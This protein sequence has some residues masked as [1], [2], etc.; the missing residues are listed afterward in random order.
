MKTSLTIS[1]V[2]LSN[3]AHVFCFGSQRSPLC[4]NKI[5]RAFWTI[6]CHYDLLH[7][8]QVSALHKPICIPPFEHSHKNISHPQWP[9]IT[10]QGLTL[11][12]TQQSSPL[13]QISINFNFRSHFPCSWEHNELANKSVTRIPPP[14]N[15]LCSMNYQW[16]H[17]EN[18]RWQVYFSVVSPFQHHNYSLTPPSKVPQ[19]KAS[20]TTDSTEQEHSTTPYHTLILNTSCTGIIL[21]L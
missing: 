6:P 11:Q 15:S 7:Q 17:K 4:D 10:V 20:S 1:I 2:W 14:P 13:K 19:S 12:E 21:K 9:K 18:K 16:P 5:H 8:L 3:F